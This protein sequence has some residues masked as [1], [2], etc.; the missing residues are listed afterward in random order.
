MMRQNALFRLGGIALCVLVVLSYYKFILPILVFNFFKTDFQQDYIGAFALLH[1]NKELYPILGPAFYEMGINWNVLHRSTH[2]PTAYLFVLPFVLVNNQA[3]QILWMTVMLV[4][5]L[6]TA[7]AF[8]LSWK[9]SLF[10]SLLSLAWPPTYFSLVQMTP[11]WLLGLALAYQY[12]QHGL[13]SGAWIAAASLTKFLPATALIYHLRRRQ[14]IALLGFI[15]VCLGALIFLLILRPDSIHAYITSNIGNSMDQLL[16][17]DNSA[18]L[19]AAWR[20]GGWPGLIAAV[21]LIIW[22]A[23]AALHRDGPAEWA[24]LVWLGVALLPIA[25]NY[26]IFPLLPWLVLVLMSPR[27]SSGLYAAAA[28]LLPFV[29]AYPTQNPEL[30]TL[31]IILAGVAFAVA[32]ERELEATVNLLTTRAGAGE[33]AAGVG[34]NGG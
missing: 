21:L 6:L 33:M 31:T 24:C 3:A 1:K 26:S 9:M 22:V 10:A 27:V 19:V 17:A 4:C 11:I 14:W 20:L 30:V 25:W 32:S 2:P 12:W 29:T 16:R 15:A 34:M 23:W 7:R 28:L 13:K 8:G 18:L 5:I